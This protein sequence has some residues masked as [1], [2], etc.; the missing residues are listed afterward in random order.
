MS[1]NIYLA[2]KFW[3]L[4]STPT[5]FLQIIP[6]RFYHYLQF[7]T[8]SFLTRK[9]KKQ[10]NKNTKIKWSYYRS[11][12]GQCKAVTLERH[13]QSKKQKLIRSEESRVLNN[14]LIVILLKRKKFWHENSSERFKIGSLFCQ[15]AEN[16]K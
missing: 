6:S 2:E 8:S 12:L 5:K 7:N 9:S 4:L 11:S 16:R 3:L 13:R 15:T 1:I 10:K 14:F